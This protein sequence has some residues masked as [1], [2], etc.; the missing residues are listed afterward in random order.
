MTFEPI[1]YKTSTRQQWEDAAEA[2]HRWGPTLELWLG[3]ATE[4]MLDAVKLQPDMSVLDVAAGAGG[5]SLAVARRVGP[6]GRVVATDISPMIL[7]YAARSA[8]EAG[9]T[10]VETLEVDGESLDER[11]AE[12]FDAVV[13]RVGLIYFPDRQRAL[14][15]MY[16]ALRP[17]G[18]L[19]PSS[20]RRPTGTSSSPCPSPSFGT[21]PSFPHPSRASPGRSAWAV[22]VCYRS[23]WSKPGSG[24]LRLR[25]SR[26]PSAWL[27][28]PS[29][30]RSSASPSAPS[31]RCWLRCPP[32][33][34]KRCGTRSAG[35]L[36]ASIPE[37]G[38]SGRA[39]FSSAP[40]STDRIRERKHLA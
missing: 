22:R 18:R 38:S 26:H 17:G 2:W 15:G 14:T 6:G 19:G 40:A 28:P 8:A 16:R 33:G 31:T 7:S 36:R 20:T 25:S 27:R 3:G 10:N 4:A 1:Q 37:T 39:S 12:S 11:P 30:S 34:V 24:T 29:A 5:Q 9:L 13:S 23:S 35:R 21:G 32:T